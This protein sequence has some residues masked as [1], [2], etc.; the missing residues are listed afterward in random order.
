MLKSIDVWHNLPISILF[1]TVYSYIRKIDADGSVH[2]FL[3]KKKDILMVLELW[4]KQK[5]QYSLSG[6]GV[7]LLYMFRYLIDGSQNAVWGLALQGLIPQ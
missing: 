1:P 4:T 2:T 5:L 7:K 3:L 6:G